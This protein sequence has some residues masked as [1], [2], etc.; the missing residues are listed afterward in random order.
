MDGPPSFSGHP[1][2]HFAVR[3]LPCGARWEGPSGQC[4]AVFWPYLSVF[5]TI[6]ERREGKPGDDR[7]FVHQ[8]SARKS[9]HKREFSIYLRSQH[10]PRRGWPAKTA[11]PSKSRAIPANGNARW[12][13][14]S[15]A[16]P[17]SLWPLL[18]CAG[19]PL[20]G[21]SRRLEC[22]G[23]GN[24]RPW[25]RYSRETQFARNSSLGRMPCIH[26][27][28]VSVPLTHRVYII[29]GMSTMPVAWAW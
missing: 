6:C 17:E 8:P 10:S 23:F 25:F 4:H 22:R 27:I 28:T 2:S 15:R 12:Q 24:H 29:H 16:K 7:E 20:P 11:S 21:G 13:C 26:W 5:C 19:S 14:L 3:S 18:S 9:R 1:T